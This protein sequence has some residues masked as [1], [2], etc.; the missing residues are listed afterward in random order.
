[1]KIEKLKEIVINL[2]KKYRH[3][4]IYSLIGVTGASLDYFTFLLFTNV[5]HWNIIFSNVLSVT[6]GVTDSFVLN[7]LFNFKVK[8]KIFLRAISFYTVG[9][10]GMGLST[11]ILHIFVTDLGFNKAIVKLLSLIVVV[12][13]QYTL[14]KAIS[15]REKKTNES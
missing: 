1:M 4:I 3:F 12:I 7:V 13:V 14:N 10:I 8:D 6:L 9:A 2:L 5:F 11:L 15:F